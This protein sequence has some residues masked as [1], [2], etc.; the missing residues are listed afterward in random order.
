MIRFPIFYFN[1]CQKTEEELPMKKII[2]NNFFF[3][4]TK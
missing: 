2:C 3:L 4:M 1:Y